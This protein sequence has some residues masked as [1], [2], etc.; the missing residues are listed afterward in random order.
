MPQIQA[1]NGQIIEFPDDLDDAALQQAVYNFRDKNPAFFELP[2]TPLPNPEDQSVFRSV[3]DVPLKTGQGFLMG[4]R[5]LS[6]AFGADNPVSAALSSGEGI[7][8][9]LMSAGSKQD[10]AEIARLFKEAEDKGVLDQVQAGLKA[11]ATAPIDVVSQALGTAAPTIAAGL[12]TGGSGYG[13]TAA[14]VATA[15]V[16]AVTG[17]GIG[18]GAIYEAVESELLSNGVDPKKASEAATK[19]QA[20]NGENLDQ[21][22]LATGLGGLAGST[23][24][25]SALFKG[26]KG[27]IVKRATRGFLAEGAPDAAQAF[28]E[29]V[30]GNIAEQ[31]GG[32]DTPTYQGATAQGT[33][34]GV[35]GGVLG[36]GISTIAP[37]QADLEISE[38]EDTLGLPSPP[39]GFELQGETKVTPYREEAQPTESLGIQGELDLGYTPE[40]KQDYEYATSGEQKLL[41]NYTPS[42]E[43]RT[44]IGKQQSFDFDQKL[45]PRPPTGIVPATSETSAIDYQLGQGELGFE[46]NPQSIGEGNFGILDLDTT[47]E[48]SGDKRLDG[49]IRKYQTRLKK[50]KSRTEQQQIISEFDNELNTRVAEGKV[51]Q[52]SLGR[53]KK[54]AKQQEMDLFFTSGFD[55]ETDADV[56]AREEAFD[57]IQGREQTVNPQAE[58]VA[59]DLRNRELESERQRV[60]DRDTEYAGELNDIQPEKETAPIYDSDYV[61][62]QTLNNLGVNENAGV[63]KRIRGLNYNDPVERAKIYDELNKYANEDNTLS[64]DAAADIKEFTRNLRDTGAPKVKDYMELSDAQ[65][66]ERLRLNGAYKAYQRLLDHYAEMANTRRRNLYNQDRK[67]RSSVNQWRAAID[68]INE[69]IKSLNDDLKIDLS[70]EELVDLVKQLTNGMRKDNGKLSLS[71]DALKKAHLLVE[72]SNRERSLQNAKMNEQYD[73]KEKELIDDAEEAGVALEMAKQKE[74]DLDIKLNPTETFQDKF[75]SNESKEPKLFSS[76]K[77]GLDNIIKTGNPFEKLL[78]RRLKQTF[79]RKIN[80]IGIIQVESVKEIPKGARQSFKR[81][82]LGMYY[83]TENGGNIFLIK[84]K[85][86]S[87]FNNRTFLH[88]LTHAATLRKIEAYTEGNLALD[89]NSKD[90]IKDINQLMRQAAKTYASI[91]GEKIRKGEKPDAKFQTLI[92]LNK[93]GAFSNINEFVAYGMTEPAMQEFLMSLPAIDYNKDKSKRL[94][95]LGKLVNAI[96]KLF[97]MGPQFANAFYDLV[98][99]TDILIDTPPFDLPPA[100]EAQANSAVAANEDSWSKVMESRDAGLL[101]SASLLNKRVWEPKKMLDI[102]TSSGPT[103]VRGLL[104]VIPTLDVMRAAEKKIDKMVHKG[105]IGKE[106]LSFDTMRELVNKTFKMAEKRSKR[107]KRLSDEVSILQSFKEVYKKRSM[108]LNG[109][110]VPIADA[111]SI[112]THVSTLDQINLRENSTLQQALNKDRTLS[113]LRKKYQTDDHMDVR[114]RINQLEKIYKGW[115]ELNALTENR[116]QTVYNHMFDYYKESYNEHIQLLKK[117]ISNLSTDSEGKKKLVNQIVADFEEKKELEVYFPLTR[118]GKHWFSVGKGVNAKFFTFES[119]SARDE[120][121]KSY[122]EKG[123]KDGTIDPNTPIEELYAT[124]DAEGQFAKDDKIDTMF[125]RDNEANAMLM[126]L[127]ATIDALDLNT[128]SVKSQLKDSVYQLY[129]AQL[130]IN[131]IRKRFHAR[132][133]KSGFN[134]DLERNLITAQHTAANQLTRLEYAGVLRNLIDQQKSALRSSQYSNTLSPYIDEIENRVMSEVNPPN[135]GI[136]AKLASAG[137]MGVFY[138]MLTN[139]RA[140]IANMTQIPMVGIPTLAAEHGMANTLKIVKTYGNISN[141]FTNKPGRAIDVEELHLD[142]EGVPRFKIAQPDFANA[143]HVQNS[144]IKDQ[145]MKAYYEADARGLFMATF[146]AD[147]TSRSQ[148]PTATY[149]S[150]FTKGTRAALDGMAF[151]FHHS[152]AMTRKIMFMSSFELEYTRMKDNLSGQQERELRKRKAHDLAAVEAAIDEGVEREPKTTDEILQDMAFDKAREAVDNTLFNYTE[153]NRPA[154][155]K[156]PVAAVT[157]QFMTFPIQMTS[158]LVRNSLAIISPL[159]SAQDKKDAATKIFG[160]IGMAGM[161][162]GVVGLPFYGAM[163]GAAEGVRELFRPDEDDDPQKQIWYDATDPT[164]PLGYRNLDLWF[165]GYWIPKMFGS[166]SDIAKALG[167]SD[168]AAELLARSIV[169]GPV[170]AL[171]DA[172]IGTST[173][174]NV[175]DMFFRLDTPTKFDENAFGNMVF[176][177]VSGAA[178]SMFKSILSGVQDIQEGQVNRG[179][180]KLLPAILRGPA[181]AFRLSEEGLLTRKG[182]EVKPEEF[183]TTAK[184]LPQVFGMSSTET[185]AIQKASFAAKQLLVEL[186]QERQDRLNR[187]NLAAM[188]YSQ[189]PSNSHYDD[190]EEA[191][192]DIMEFNYK[193]GFGPLYID[194]KTI[195][196]SITGQA[197]RR[198]SALQGLMTSS[199]KEMNLAYPLVEGLT[200]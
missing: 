79:G 4:I 112:I 44:D 133:G 127:E 93:V 174:I 173:N 54:P 21:I 13:L 57:K 64:S 113:I 42:Q 7:L 35:A 129:L 128:P 19:A 140:A 165:R 183:Y 103:A 65:Q 141:I 100:K 193:N 36:A 172:N 159:K 49:T 66:L 82:V 196:S 155:M 175:T 124:P 28:Q 16:G 120:Y 150:P 137:R 186:K 187:L 87:G 80:N 167:L 171:T 154:A 151:L 180:E 158:Y 92:N 39:R 176:D 45:L 90:T 135:E 199:D 195:H 200:K 88:E 182:A 51:K 30:A 53:R 143:R 33:L 23:G 77:E 197:E 184:L 27:G 190:M 160:T 50:A 26:L 86:R 168:E 10:S 43:E 75:V 139:P 59:Y 91:Y 117:A 192:V 126:E 191:L 40:Q 97:N 170:S 8:E 144:P 189:E 76:V 95:M 47:T 94:G 12:L 6:D 1:P 38:V 142:N 73:K 32:L 115:E 20:Y 101:N 31:R 162:S 24:V 98:A 166:D 107:L 17:A 194:S 122:Y 104:K 136:T 48:S 89:A 178:G 147:M 41:P 5:F 134:M 119:A 58:D 55:A 29:K 22:L 185:D 52:P 34:E 116:A 132:S 177:L 62:D 114:E 157:F 3:A 72:F 60:R 179:V 188:R 56:Q 146:A 156:N 2:T 131:D 102:I 148:M 14:R 164:N 85:Q 61:T 9:K 18:K 70:K 74:K 161:F 83:D 37:T 111:L 149:D 123:V 25:E 138:Y 169:M 152:E 125:R 106:D 198:G 181:K 84:N 145:L 118:Y 69:N 153:F 96:R 68:I 67:A 81:G 46:Y 110:S 105:Q 109:E 99:L 15:G 71:E 63:R 121:I 78:A 163:V 130:P 108:N 11:F